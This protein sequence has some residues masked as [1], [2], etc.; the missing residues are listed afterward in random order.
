[1]V[2]LIAAL[3]RLNSEESL[4]ESMVQ[5]GHFQAF[6]GTE[7]KWAT[8]AEVHLLNLI[9]ETPNDAFLWN[10]LGNVYNRGGVP[11]LAVVAFEQ[12]LR[13]DNGQVE[14]HVSLAN[15]LYHF[16][17]FDACIH[18]SHLALVHARFYTKLNP[19][20]LHDMLCILLRN[21]LDAT[22]VMGNTD[23]FL[24]PA[25]LAKSTAE[26]HGKPSTS[27]ERVLDIRAFDFYLD[28]PQ[29]FSGLANIYLGK[30]ARSQG[31]GAYRRHR[32]KKRRR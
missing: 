10:R 11:E 21:L 5:L 20:S 9:C 6:D 18:H 1:M 31:A 30:Q 25:E 17:E 32:A 22:M 29:S 12:S 4:E 24:P 28:D 13:Y 7:P 3:F 23:L 19:Q 15:I 14:S 8:D 26:Q 16:D 2:F 27:L